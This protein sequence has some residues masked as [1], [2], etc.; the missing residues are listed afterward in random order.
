MAALGATFGSLLL[1]PNKRAHLSPAMGPAPYSYFCV[2]EG[3][4]TDEGEAAGEGACGWHLA[5]AK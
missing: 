3:A 2:L 5:A 1:D 4:V